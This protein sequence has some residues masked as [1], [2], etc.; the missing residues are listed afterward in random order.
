M[1]S[2]DVSGYV[3]FYGSF[4][5]L[6]LVDDKQS[7]TLEKNMLQFSRQEMK[8]ATVRML[9]VQVESTCSSHRNFYG[10]HIHG[11]I[12]NFISSNIIQTEVL[13]LVNGRKYLSTADAFLKCFGTDGRVTYIR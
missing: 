7:G 3:L 13:L 6:Y 4:L 2:K 10:K 5:S 1:L 11:G 9:T 8:T 12:Y